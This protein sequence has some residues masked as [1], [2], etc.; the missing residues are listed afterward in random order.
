MITYTNVVTSLYRHKCFIGKF[1]A[2]KTHKKLHPGP[3]WQIF[4]IVTSENIGDTFSRLFNQ[5][6]TLTIKIKIKL[7]S[8]LKIHEFYFL[9]L[10]K[11]FMH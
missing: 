1:K 11:Y 10:K 9:V 5:T 3:K 2:L 7:H 8:G 4:H 6:V